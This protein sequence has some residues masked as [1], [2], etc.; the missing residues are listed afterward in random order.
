MPDPVELVP[1]RVAHPRAADVAAVDRVLA[2][3]DDLAPHAG[4]RCTLAP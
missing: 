3:G 1:R 2:P 4:T